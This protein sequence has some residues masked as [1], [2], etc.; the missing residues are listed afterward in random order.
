[1]KPA[2]SFS[3][4]PGNFPLSALQDKGRYKEVNLETHDSG[5]FRSCGFLN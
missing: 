4:E 2:I 5:Q 1:M 3:P